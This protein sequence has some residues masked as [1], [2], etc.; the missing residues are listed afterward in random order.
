MTLHSAKGLEFPHVYL[1]GMEEGL[2][3]HHRVGGG[4]RGGDRRRAAAVLRRRHAGPGPA[5]LDPCR[6]TRNKWGKPRPH[7]AQPVFVRTAGQG[8]QPRVAAE[9]KTTTRLTQRVAPKVR[10]SIAQNQL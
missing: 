3:P 1:V 2:L 6:C 5:D 10:H 8:R 4:R 9:E 7:D